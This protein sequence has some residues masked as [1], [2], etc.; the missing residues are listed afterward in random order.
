MKGAQLLTHPGPRGFYRCNQA[1]ARICILALLAGCTTVTVRAP[2]CETPPLPAHALDPCE[3]PAPM[4][5]GSL[6]AF[7]LQNFVDTAIVKC[8]AKQFNNLKAQIAH[9][10]AKVKECQQR[11][12]PAADKPWWR[13]GQ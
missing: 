5:D 12:Q 13:F 1:A 9:R 7:Y 3:L 11:D 4:V 2:T 10:D 6:E 8:W